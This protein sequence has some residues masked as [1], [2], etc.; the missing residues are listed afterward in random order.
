M[1]AFAD[2]ID[3]L[4]AS[5]L[6]DVSILAAVDA[7]E[8]SAK[9]L[10]NLVIDTRKR[11]GVSLG[12]ASAESYVARTMG[13]WSTNKRMPPTARNIAR[14]IV[15]R[16]GRPSPRTASHPV[17]ANLA[18]DDI[19]SDSGSGTR[20]LSLQVLCGS[21]VLTVQPAAHGLRAGRAACCP[22]GGRGRRTAYEAPRQGEARVV[23]TRKAGR[24]IVIEAPETPALFTAVHA[25]KRALRVGRV[26]RA[27]RNGRRR[28]ASA[29]CSGRWW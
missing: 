21:K 18:I 19:H 20:H 25:G 7:Y 11:G 14:G 9:K 23:P 6:R 5:T 1:E 15:R 16:M 12:D 22:L 29:K 10:R 28:P 27:W 13:G 24:R 26:L 8:L 3:G 2:Q 4:W 17:W